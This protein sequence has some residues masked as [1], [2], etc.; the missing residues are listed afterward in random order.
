[1]SMMKSLTV[2]AAALTVAT[3]LAS[4]PASAANGRHAAFAAG[5]IGAL[6]VGALAAGAMNQPA[7]A[8]PPAYYAEPSCWFE[9]QP[10][11]DAWGRFIRYER[12]RVCN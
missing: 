4:A 9:R 5:A 1:M 2:A 11:Y 7:Y 10:V 8:A 3:T 6:A 12:V